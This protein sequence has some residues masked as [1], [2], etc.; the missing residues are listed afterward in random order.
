MLVRINNNSG[1]VSEWCIL[2]FQGEMIADSLE[3][4]ELGKLDIFEVKK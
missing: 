4:K 3:D 1:G 2:E